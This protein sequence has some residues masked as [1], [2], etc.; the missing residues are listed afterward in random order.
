MTGKLNGAVTRIKNA[1]KN[2]KS[3]HCIIHRYALVTKNISPL[4]KKVLDEAVQIVN[5]IKSRPLQCRIFKQLCE[6][7]DSEQLSIQP[8]YYI[9]KLDGCPE[10]RSWLE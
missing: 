10:E 4:L 6:S 9:L 5:F 2:C 8:C 7:M 1:S 3:V